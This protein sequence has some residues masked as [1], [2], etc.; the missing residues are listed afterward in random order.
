MVLWSIFLNDMVIKC[1]LSSKHTM[2][3]ISKP[4][5]P[6]SMIQSLGRLSA[7]WVSLHHRD[8]HLKMT[9]ILGRASKVHTV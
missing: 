5:E 7:D 8:T 9:E 6:P 3:P 2:L 4:K 1:Q